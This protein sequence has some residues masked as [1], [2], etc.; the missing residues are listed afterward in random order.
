MLKPLNDIEKTINLIATVSNTPPEDVHERL[1]AEVREIGTYSYNCLKSRDIPLYQ[2]SE[3][4]NE[5]WRDRD[6]FLYEI[7]VWNTSGDLQKLYHHQ[8]FSE[9][10]ASFFWDPIVLQK[11]D[12]PSAYTRAPGQRYGLLSSCSR[13]GAGTA[14]FIH[15]CRSLDRTCPK[16]MAEDA[17]CTKS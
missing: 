11:T 16:V 1:R 2:T 12:N 9:V 15:N 4:L 7:T 3:K 14:H 6:A 8:G 10:D 13:L 5:L 17:E